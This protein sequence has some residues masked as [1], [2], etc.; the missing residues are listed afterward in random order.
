MVSRA[1]RTPFGEWWWTVDKLTLAALGALMLAGIVLS[2]AASPEVAGRLGLDPFYFVDRQIFYLIPTITVLLAVSFLT[3]R[4]IRRRLR[5]LPFTRIP[6][7][8]WCSAPTARR[9]CAPVPPT[10]SPA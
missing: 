5:R 7:W 9:P 8:E 2:L 1:Q 4:L 3:P 10:P 6:V